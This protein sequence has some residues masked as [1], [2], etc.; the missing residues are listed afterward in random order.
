MGSPIQVCPE[1]AR[2]L[3]LLFFLGGI[4]VHP[5]ALVIVIDERG[6]AM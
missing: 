4:I 3:C 1:R 6:A 5:L 2:S